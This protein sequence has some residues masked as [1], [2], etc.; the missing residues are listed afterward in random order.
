MLSSD[1]MTELSFIH[2]VYTEA[3]QKLGLSDTL[4]G[5]KSPLHE[6]KGIVEKYKEQFESSPTNPE[7]SSAP[8]ETAG[9]SRSTLR[10]KAYA[11]GLKH[12]RQ[13]R[14]LDPNMEGTFITRKYVFFFQKSAFNFC[15]KLQTSYRKNVW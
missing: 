3:K 7:I 13:R 9:S 5:L 14:H 12:T 11:E 4:T 15:R 10:S 1:I 6:I 2:G 8:E